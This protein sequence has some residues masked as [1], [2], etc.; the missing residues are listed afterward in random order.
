M[1]AEETFIETLY[2]LLMNYYSIGASKSKVD[3]VMLQFKEAKEEFAESQN[4][5]LIEEN[6][7]LKN[8]LSCIVADCHP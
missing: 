8:T 5:E 3:K 4:K 2:D 1:K 6:N 7:Q